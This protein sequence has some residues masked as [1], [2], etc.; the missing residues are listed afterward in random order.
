MKIRLIHLL[1]IVSILLSGCQSAAS[2]RSYKEIEIP[3][4]MTNEEAA[5]LQSLQ[6]VDSYPLYT[7]QYNGPLTLSDNTPV[8]GTSPNMGKKN[9]PGENNL[10]AEWSCTLFAALGDPD[11]LFFGRNFDWEFSPTLLLFNH[12][13]DGYS[14]VSMVDISYLGFSGGEN[15]LD[16]PLNERR[17]LLHAVE[18]PFD[19]MNDQGLAIGM[20]AVPS[21]GQAAAPGKPSIDSLLV[22][23]E[24][25]DASRTVDEALAILEKYNILW[26][27]GPPLH[28]LIADAHGSSVL[29]EYYQGKMNQIKN[30]NPWHLATNFFVTP[31]KDNPAGQCS[32]Y[33][34]AQ[35]TLEESG[36][37]LTSGESMDLL[38]QVNQPNTQWSILYGM[39]SGEIRISMGSDKGEDPMIFQLK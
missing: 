7:M 4:G 8:T 11:N 14:S 6:L 39:T 17:N 21:D 10:R 18:I 24:V 35:K 32:R 28:Y 13:V 2:S 31:V 38:H 12:P 27:S 22:M 1:F 29:V 15:L 30:V 3:A 9:A 25:L 20:A 34:Q 36:G 26:G 16:I 23:R 33:D 37:I 5:S 19:G